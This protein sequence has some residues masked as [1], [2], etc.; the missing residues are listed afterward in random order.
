MLNIAKEGIWNQFG[1]SIDMLENA[2]NA[3]PEVHWATD[4][5]FWYH[6]FHCLFFTDYYLSLEPK[7]FSP[8]EPFT[9]SE[10]EDKMPE[11]VYT[12]DELL[13]YSQ[14]CRD[15]CRHLI[16]G[17]TEDAFNA[18]WINQSGTMDYSVFEILLYNMRHVQHHAA[19][20]NLIL[21]QTIDDAPDWVSRASDKI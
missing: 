8:P 1:A 5:K 4:S 15:K 18:R 20:L 21:R 12:K 6:A 13:T 16:S 14:F 7:T 3:C 19:Q 9:E 10:F 11:C 2:I 17:L